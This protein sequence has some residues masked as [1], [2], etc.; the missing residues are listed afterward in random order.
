MDELRKRGQATLAVK[1]T[2]KRPRA[3]H[4]KGTAATPKRVSF[5]QSDFPL[6]SLPQAQKIASAIVDNF[7]AKEGPPPDI[8]LAIGSSPTSSTWRDLAGSSVAYGLTEGSQQATSIKLTA[9]GRKLAAP[10]EEGEDLV[11]RRSAILIHESAK[12]SSSAT[13]VQNSLM[14]QLPRMCLGRW[15]FQLTGLALHLR[16]SKRMADMRGSYAKLRLVHS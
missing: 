3:L 11:A 16:F 10:E 7:A 1:K 2:S 8:A 6:V 5:R 14:K 4:A 12:S 9:L 15:A 13:V